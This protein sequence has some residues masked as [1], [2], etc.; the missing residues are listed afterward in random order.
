MKTR[1]EAIAEAQKAGAEY[2]TRAKALKAEGLSKPAIARVLGITS[3]GGWDL[4][5]TQKVDNLLKD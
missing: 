4:T 2:K 1:E 5:V 3:G